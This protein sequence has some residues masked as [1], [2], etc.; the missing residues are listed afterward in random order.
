MFVGDHLHLLHAF[1]SRHRVQWHVQPYGGFVTA[2]NLA[3]HMF[4][5]LSDINDKPLKTTQFSSKLFWQ[6]LVHRCTL[7]E[8]ETFPFQ[9][10]SHPLKSDI[11]TPM[12][13]AISTAYIFIISL[14][15][16]SEHAQNPQPCLPVVGIVLANRKK[17]P[18]SGC[19][20]TV[21]FSGTPVCNRFFRHTE[22]A[23]GSH[24]TIFF[25]KLYCAPFKRCCKLTSQTAFHTCRQMNTAP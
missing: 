11:E 23:L 4:R 1:S 17:I 22:L 19:T 24:V 15:T 14:V 7:P 8:S 2:T 25:S 16:G 3:K 13:W 6:L 20:D 5:S 10:P 9:K 12:P 21:P 18:S